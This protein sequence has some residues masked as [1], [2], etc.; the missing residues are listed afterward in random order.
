MEEAKARMEK[1][2]V[3]N[4]ERGK[5]PEKTRRINENQ[6]KLI[7]RGEWE[8]GRTQAALQTYFTRLQRLALG[9]LSCTSATSGLLAG[10]LK[11]PPKNT[12]S[13]QDATKQPKTDTNARRTGKT[14]RNVRNTVNPVAAV[15]LE[16]AYR[17]GVRGAPGE[18]SHDAWREGGS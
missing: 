13:T 9:H 4:L 17:R 10:R 2:A 18:Q 16:A 12:R 14:G 3:K 1:T 11:A 15:C 7:R 5:P 6:A 8:G